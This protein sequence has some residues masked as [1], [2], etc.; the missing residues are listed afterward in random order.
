MFPVFIEK[1][2][3]KFCLWMYHRIYINLHGSYE[4]VGM[5]LE[6]HDISF[7]LIIIFAYSWH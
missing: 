6:L 7:Y 5:T 2:V 4:K 3:F 1:K